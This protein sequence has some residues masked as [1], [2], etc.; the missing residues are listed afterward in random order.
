MDNAGAG[1]L[2]IAGA[3]FFFLVLPLLLRLAVFVGES[4]VD[5]VGF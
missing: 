2:D 4:F 1:L 3:F 5:F